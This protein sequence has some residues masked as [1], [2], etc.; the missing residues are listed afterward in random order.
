MLFR[1]MQS[2]TTL[3]Y[4]AGEK[5]T[6]FCAHNQGNET[7]NKLAAAQIIREVYFSLKS[8]GCTCTDQMGIFELVH[9][10][11]GR[12]HHSLAHTL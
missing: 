9:S 1:S 4:T 2:C 10:L 7:R 11:F 6:H 5:V 12:K 3:D 8:D